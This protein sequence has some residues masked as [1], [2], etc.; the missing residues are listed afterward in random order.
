MSHDSNKEQSGRLRQLASRMLV[1]CSGTSLA[2][3]LMFAFSPLLTRL[4]SPASFAVLGFHQATLAVLAMVLTLQYEVA[5]PIP[6]EEK[7]ANVLL[8]LSVRVAVILTVLTTALAVIWGLLPISAQW[9]M[10]LSALAIIP[11]CSLGEAVA[12][13]YRLSCIRQAQFSRLSLARVLQAVATV[14]CHIVTGVFGW[15][16]L[17][18]PLG[19]GLGRWAAAG[20]FVWLSRSSGA[21]KEPQPAQTISLADYRAAMQRYMQFPTFVMPGV[22]IASLV[23]VLPALVLPSLYGEEFAGQF[24]LANRSVLMPLMVISQAVT[25]I[26]VSD[27]SKYLR[28]QDPSLRTL[29]RTTAV[30]MGLLGLVLSIGAALTGPLLFPLVFGA[31]WS[32]AGHIVPLLALSAFAQFVGGP[33]NQVLVLLG[34]ESRKLLLNTI[35]LVSVIA[36]LFVSH[37]LGWGPITATTAYAITILGVQTLYLWQSIAVVEEQATAWERDRAEAIPFPPASTQAI[38]PQRR[39]A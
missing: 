25:Q 7:Q 27:A 18:L 1:L 37:W 26:Y 12:R 8:K 33:V 6:E 17:G 4:F 14:A 39:V 20:Y 5:I 13:S 9:W 3:L 28:N 10:P 35:G 29:I 32:V 22:I 19:D 2:H 11:I 23:N 38:P 16:T 24:A 21:G 36:V 34:K 15:L 30:Q 31:K